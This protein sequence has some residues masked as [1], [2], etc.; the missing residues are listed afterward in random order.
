VAARGLNDVR[1]GYVT[2]VKT[3]VGCDHADIRQLCRLGDDG[4]EH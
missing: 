3:I 4:G 1:L 2:K